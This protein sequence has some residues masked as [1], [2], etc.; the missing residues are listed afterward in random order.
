LWYSH[1]LK[2]ESRK[3]IYSVQNYD[4]IMQNA[5]DAEARSQQLE[6]EG[7]AN[8]T[9]QL[10]ISTRAALPRR[11]DAE[12]DKSGLKTMNRSTTDVRLEFVLNGSHVNALR[13]QNKIE[14]A[15]PELRL[16]SVILTGQP[17]GSVNLSGI[18]DLWPI[19]KPSAK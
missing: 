11:L 4:A 8:F 3:I 16:R 15:F 17:D 13:F 9:Y 10:S 18:W 19:P 5:K 6:S 2:A 12:I 14:T 1:K 7:A